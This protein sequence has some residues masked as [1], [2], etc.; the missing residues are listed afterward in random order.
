MSIKIS[1]LTPKGANLEATDLLEI[2]QVTADGYVSKSIT[3]AEIINAIPVP[4]LNPQTIASVNGTNL[5]GTAIQISASV[6]IPAGTILTNNT[7]YLKC[8]LTKTAGV[9]N[10]IPRLYINTSNSLTGATLL[11]AGQ[12]MGTSV[13]FQRFERNIF[14]DGTNLNHLT[15]AG[16]NAIDLTSGAINLTAFNPATN[17]YLIFA[18][19]NSTATPDNLGWKRVIVQKYD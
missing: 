3:G 13:Y 11:A 5:T 17:Y 18:V 9:T 10:S 2:S 14:F 4:T 15:N 8:L 6:L 19:Q 12:T 1:E 7:I 16:S